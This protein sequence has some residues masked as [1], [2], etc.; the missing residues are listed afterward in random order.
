MLD[1]KVI[2]EMLLNLNPYMV[3]AKVMSMTSWVY[4]TIRVKNKM[5]GIAG[6]RLNK[7]ELRLEYQ[8]TV[9]E[10]WLRVKTGMRMM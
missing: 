9:N 8:K 6:E 2:C 3:I 5:T 7:R 1:T 10:K 4:K